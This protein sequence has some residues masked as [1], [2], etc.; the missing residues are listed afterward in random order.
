MSSND[1]QFDDWFESHA[2]ARSPADE[3]IDICAKALDAIVEVRDA[4]ES[5]NTQAQEQF[6]NFAVNHPLDTVL[7]RIEVHAKAIKWILF[8]ILL[9]LLFK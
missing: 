1:Q 9:V 2:S 7:R 3:A 8:A 4:I 6:T 5:A